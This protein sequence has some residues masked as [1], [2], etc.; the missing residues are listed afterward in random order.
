MVHEDLFD[1]PDVARSIRRMRAID[2]LK[3]RFGRR[4]VITAPSTSRFGDA[5]LLESARQA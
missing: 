2:Q 4:A 3:A 1:R 5:V